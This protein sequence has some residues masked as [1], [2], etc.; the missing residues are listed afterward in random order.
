[1]TGRVPATDS[2]ISWRQHGYSYY[3]LLPAGREYVQ[4]LRQRHDAPADA[5]PQVLLDVNELAAD[6]DYVELGLWRVS[7]DGTRLAWSVDFE[8][9]EV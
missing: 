6:A 3:T 7:P 9:D 4:L 1:M 5:A 2:S 8:G